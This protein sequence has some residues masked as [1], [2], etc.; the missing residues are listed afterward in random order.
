MQLGEAAVSAA[1]HNL[2]HLVDFAIRV[3]TEGRRCGLRQVGEWL[4]RDTL[5]EKK[6][7]GWA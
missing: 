5:E 3:Q 4:M 6:K 7:G 2:V 1:S